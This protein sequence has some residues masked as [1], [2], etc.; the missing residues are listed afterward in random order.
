MAT[1]VLILD[2]VILQKI[3]WTLFP[4]PARHPKGPFYMYSIPLGGGVLR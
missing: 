4:V 2:Q 3:P 1:P